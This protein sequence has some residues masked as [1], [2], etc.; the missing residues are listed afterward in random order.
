[1]VTETA[2]ARERGTALTLQTALGFLLTIVTIRGVPVLA[3]WWGWRWAFPILALGP[4][5]GIWAMARLRRSPEAAHLAG[6]LG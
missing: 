2:D 6:G 1:M 4:M 5:A 3:D